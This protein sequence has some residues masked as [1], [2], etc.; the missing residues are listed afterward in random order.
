MTRIISNWA[1][2]LTIVLCGVALYLYSFSPHSR[3]R[4]G[5]YGAP[6]PYPSEESPRTRYYVPDQK[7][8]ERFTK[9]LRPGAELIMDIPYGKNLDC[10]SYDG[11]TTVCGWQKGKWIPYDDLEKDPD[12]PELRPVVSRFKFVSLE[13]EKIILIPF[14]YSN[15][16]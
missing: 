7:I 10:E 13:T 11:N 15:K 3:S 5:G 2:G 14:V 6:A 8:T 12:H 9:V 16:Y 4:A 1:I